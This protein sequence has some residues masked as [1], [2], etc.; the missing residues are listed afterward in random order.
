MRLSRANAPSRAS[1]LSRP[2][3]LA[4]LLLALALAPTYRALSAPRPTAAPGSGPSEVD[5][6]PQEG[7]PSE[8]P[9]QED[10]PLPG[11][12]PGVGDELDPFAGLLPFQA[13]RARKYTEALVGSW[14]LVGF[15]HATKQLTGLPIAGV[16]TLTADGFLHNIIHTRNP[17]R[18]PLFNGELF[19]QG[20]VHHWRVDGDGMLQ[21]SSIVAHSNFSGD[22]VFELPTT[23]R[24]YGIEFM[25]EEQSLNLIRPDTSRLRLERIQGGVFPANAAARIKAIKAGQPPLFGRR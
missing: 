24:E 13:E 20:G 18:N 6:N 19:V 12:E 9:E 8:K 23:L 7:A 17:D 16:L 3:P 25:L 2:H 1:D 11:D 14:Q 10:E 22:M 21:L 4:A 5:P 15:D